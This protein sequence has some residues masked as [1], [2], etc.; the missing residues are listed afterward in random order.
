MNNHILQT[1]SNWNAV[2]KGGSFE[3]LYNEADKKQKNANDAF[4]KAS[5]M[6]FLDSFSDRFFHSYIFAGAGFVSSEFVLFLLDKTSITASA[7]KTII[8][9]IVIFFYHKFRNKKN[10]E[11]LEIAK[12]QSDEEL[13]I[14]DN[15]RNELYNIQKFELLQPEFKKYCFQYS[16]NESI[17]NTFLYNIVQRQLTPYQVNF[18]VEFMEQYCRT[19][20][21]QANISDLKKVQVKNGS[22]DKP[23]E[24]IN[25]FSQ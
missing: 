22:N 17:F 19:N 9:F 3:R 21:P 4:N 15:L 12:N 23:S 24:E 10:F 25:F 13:K 2:L 1:F 6:S 20:I 5:K 14:F 7:F 16:R 18:F 11:D 8:F